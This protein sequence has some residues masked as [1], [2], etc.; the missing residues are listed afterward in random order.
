MKKEFGE[1]GGPGGGGHVERLPAERRSVDLC[2]E[3]LEIYLPAGGWGGPEIRG[4]VEKRGA[5]GAEV[6]GPLSSN[7]AQNLPK[8]VGS[9]QVVA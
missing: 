6:I 8:G 3:I 4:A 1:K 2:M 5:R 7:L 9:P